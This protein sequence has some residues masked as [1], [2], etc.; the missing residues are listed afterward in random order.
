MNEETNSKKPMNKV[1]NLV[2]D[3]QIN[4]NIMTKCLIFMSKSLPTKVHAKTKT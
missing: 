2:Q 4:K 3:S 1:I